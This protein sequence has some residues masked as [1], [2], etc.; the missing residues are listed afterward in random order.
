MRARCLP[1]RHR[2]LSTRALCDSIPPPHTPPRL[3]LHVRTQA[4]SPQLDFQDISE[5]KNRWYFQAV[6]APLG[7]LFEVSVTAEPV[8][9]APVN[10]PSCP[11]HNL[12]PTRSLRDC[13]CFQRRS[14]PLTQLLRQVGITQFTPIIARFPGKTL[15]GCLCFQVASVCH[16]ASALQR[17]RDCT[18][19]EAHQLDPPTDGGQ[20]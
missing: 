15:R 1:F 18:A 19:V 9:A 2:E 7:Q 14:A 10:Y 8:A 11:R 4:S 13:S 17:R 20:D 16:H 6:S 3:S 12:I 5:K